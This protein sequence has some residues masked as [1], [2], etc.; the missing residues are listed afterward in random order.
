MSF[1][2]W[3]NI[4][5]WILTLAIV[6]EINLIGFG[7]MKIVVQQMGSKQLVS[8]FKLSQHTLGGRLLD[9]GFN[10]SH[11]FCNMG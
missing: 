2:T 8:I 11:E 1:V 7:L 6:V 9:I 3:V 4:V 5:S 10:A